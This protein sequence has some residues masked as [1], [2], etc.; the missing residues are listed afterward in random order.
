MQFRKLQETRQ[1]LVVAQL[2]QQAAREGLR[3]N[4][5]KFRFTAA[6]LSFEKSSG[7]RAVI[8]T[9]ER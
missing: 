9:E 6:V 7:R 3:V 4:T 8:Q 1:A 5:N 2:A